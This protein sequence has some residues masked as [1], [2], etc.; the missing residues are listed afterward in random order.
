MIVVKSIMFTVVPITNAGKSPVVW[1][2]IHI[3]LPHKHGH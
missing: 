2:A 1:Q 3:Y